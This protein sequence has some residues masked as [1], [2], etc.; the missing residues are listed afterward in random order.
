MIQF[1]NVAK[2]YGSKT[3]LAD[4]S[5]SIRKGVITAIL[6]ENGSGK[7]TML[8]IFARL[9]PREHGSIRIDGR[10]METFKSLE[11]AQK[12][13]ILQQSHTLQSRV[14]VRDFVSFGRY[15]Y[16][17][18]ELDDTDWQ[19]VEAAMTYMNCKEYENSFIDELSGGQLQR[20][21]LAMILA[22]D[23]D[24]I[25]LDEPLNNLDLKHAHEMMS[26]FRDVAHKMDKTVIMVIHDVNLAFQY[27]DD[28]IALKNGE[29]VALGH[30]YETLSESVLNY[31]YDLE[32]SF[33]EINKKRFV[34]V[35]EE[36]E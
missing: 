11:F 13:A 14:R 31:I 24:V 35:K 3:A 33:V 16:N 26:Y 5:G 7:S 19:H 18:K 4:V 21:Y 20:A 27:A 28:V 23:S 30:I 1:I 32:F 34:Y 6:G 29:I 10:D 22:Q 15:P 9:L 8:K 25:L 36:K 2:H 17:Q 12:V